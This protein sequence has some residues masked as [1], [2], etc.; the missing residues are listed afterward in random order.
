M[1]NGTKMSFCN[2]FKIDFRFRRTLILNYRLKKFV[3]TFSHKKFLSVAEKLTLK[4]S[5]LKLRLNMT[6]IPT[7]TLPD[8][9]GWYQNKLLP[10]IQNQDKKK[11]VGYGVGIFLVAGKLARIPTIF[12]QFF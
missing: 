10:W 1:P 7:P 5:Y 4:N 6:E 11:L 12:V 2:I 9:G 8:A 3:K